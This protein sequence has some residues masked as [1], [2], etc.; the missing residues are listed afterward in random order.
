MSDH[1]PDPFL[2]QTGYDLNEVEDLGE[3]HDEQFEFE[4]EDA[5]DEL[6]IEEERAREG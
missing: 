2:S 4:A 5:D 3:F 1:T 6:A